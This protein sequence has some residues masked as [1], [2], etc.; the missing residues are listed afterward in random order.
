MPLPPGLDPVTAGRFGLWLLGQRNHQAALR[1]RI[2]KRR[3]YRATR[4]QRFA[5]LFF[6]W[7]VI[8]YPGCELFLCQLCMVERRVVQRWLAGHRPLPSNQARVIAD[9][10]EGLDGPAVAR[11]LRAY[12][13]ARD[14]EVRRNTGPMHKAAARRVKSG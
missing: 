12:A 5:T 8:D 7:L 2:G 4:L 3:V 6:P 9:Y 11:E 10:V 14:R 13:D 1:R